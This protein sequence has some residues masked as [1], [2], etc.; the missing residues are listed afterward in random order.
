MRRLL[1]ICFAVGL[2][3]TVHGQTPTASKCLPPME[4]APLVVE[5]LNHFVTFRCQSA[6]PIDLIRAVGFQTRIPIGVAMGKDIDALSKKARAYDLDRVDAASALSVAIEG[7]GYSIEIRDGVTVLMAGDLTAYQR[8]LVTHS[9]TDFNP[10]KAEIM[11]SLG[12]MLTGWLRAFIDPTTGWGG[13]ILSSTNEEKLNLEV[14]TPATTEDIANRIVRMGSCGMWIFKG[15]AS[16]QSPVSA[17]SIDIEP[18]Q[19]YTNKVMAEQSSSPRA[20]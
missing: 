16:H 10:G 17:T 19:H 8:E 9:F 1:Y 4:F 14:P 15:G 12:A 7:T 13:S 2:G 18:Y 11:V 20:F 6:F 3:N 5:N